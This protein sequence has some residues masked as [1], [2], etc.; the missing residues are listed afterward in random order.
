VKL[1]APLLPRPT[2][3]DGVTAVP[4][5]VSVTVTVQEEPWLM[6]MEPGEQLTLVLVERFEM[7]RSNVSLLP[8]WVAVALKVAVMVCV[9]AP[10]GV[11][12]ALHDATPVESSESEQEP[13]NP[14]LPLVA[15]PTVPDGVMAEPALVSV[16][17][18][19]QEEPSLM[20]MDAGLHERS[21]LVARFVTVSAPLPELAA[22][23]ESPP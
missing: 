7:V 3:P 15:S 10:L 21:V 2:V 17:V 4:A 5:D 8:R 23:P 12:V 18:T 13:L 11:Y 6:T 20:T 9:L 22:C 16:T 1:P 19:V 14:P